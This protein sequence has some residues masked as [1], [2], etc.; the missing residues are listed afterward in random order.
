[1]TYKVSSG[2]L[3]LYSLLITHRPRLFY[4]LFDQSPHSSLHQT[5]DSTGQC[6]LPT[7]SGVTSTC[8]PPGTPRATLVIRADP[9]RFTKISPT[10]DHKS[11]F[12]HRK[13][14]SVWGPRPQTPTGLRPWTP[15]GDFCPPDPW[16]CSPG[17]I[18]WLRHCLLSHFCYQMH[19]RLQ[20]ALIVILCHNYV[21]VV[22]PYCDYSAAFVSY[23]V[24]Q[25]WPG[26]SPH[27]CNNNGWCF[28]STWPISCWC[29]EKR[30][31]I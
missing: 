31:T 10:W 24:C 23:R 12:F 4:K 22:I 29:F 18:S 6:S 17:K 19:C 21:V 2:T 25:G 5:A 7:V 26:I 13:V 28:D 11:S 8:S 3:G 27:D 1:M 14:V 20:I 15:L 9:R 16:I 30:T